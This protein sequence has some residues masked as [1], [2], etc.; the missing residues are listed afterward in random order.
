MRK[1]SIKYIVVEMPHDLTPLKEG[2]T[3]AF[4]SSQILNLPI[5]DQDR[6]LKDLEQNNYNGAF[7]MFD[8][9]AGKVVTYDVSDLKSP[10]R[11]E[12]L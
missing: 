3:K 10:I 11:I 1:T 2:F 4:L 9:Y 7:S 12:D 5:G 8:C 6:I